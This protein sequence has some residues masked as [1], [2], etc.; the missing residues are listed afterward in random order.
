MTAEF[1]GIHPFMK[2]VA[3]ERTFSS[4]WTISVSSLS[5]SD[6]EGGE[7]REMTSKHNQ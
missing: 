5:S 2:H 6:C 7:N 1:I 4:S 3:V